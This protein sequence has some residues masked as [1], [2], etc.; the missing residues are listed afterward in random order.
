MTTLSR[1]KLLEGSTLGLGLFLWP[2]PA[3]ASDE[4]RIGVVGVGGR[5]N[6]NL[7]A[8]AS[9][10]IAALCDVDARRL[11]EAGKR[12]P[13]AKRYA[14][15]RRML[16]TERL[17]AV[18]VST[19]DHTHAAVALAALEAGHHVYCEKPL[20]HTVGEV[21]R[22]RALAAEK[23]LVTQMGTQIHATDN[24]RRVV[25]RVRAGQLG[26]VRE[27]HVFCAKDWGADGRPQEEHE[28]PAAL[29]YDLWLGPVAQTAFHNSFHPAGWRR[30]WPFG[31]GTL[32]DMAC[33]YV[34]LPFWALELDAPTNVRASGPQVDNFAAPRSLEVHYDFPARAERAAL[35]LSWYDGGRRPEALARYG[36]DAWQNGVLFIGERGALL[37]D[38]SRHLLLPEER[39]A[40][41][42]APAA[43]IAP[44]IGHHREWIEACKS[45]GETSCN[46]D[47]SGALSETVLLGALA[48]RAE[49]EIDWDGQAGVARGVDLAHWIDP[50]R[51]EGWKL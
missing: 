51:R 41:L 47:Y 17:D 22:M 19:P 26:A 29:N 15:F 2:R 32:A 40:E 14:D 16:D 1:R 25:E 10:H 11:G 4:L 12:F 35:R 38:Y 49:R 28:V 24:Y 8:V 9:E 21:R 5:G 36:Q 44:S 39:F 31:G 3:R 6:A 23:G 18:V 13:Q 30:Y 43:S 45:G 48:Y 7:Q 50:E 27:V 34:D 33:H 42:A 37:S 46:F 20:A